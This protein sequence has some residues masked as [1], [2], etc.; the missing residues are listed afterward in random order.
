MT[1]KAFRLQIA[2]PGQS[3]R[4]VVI[5]REVEAGRECDGI[6]LDDPTASRRHVSLDPTD[7]GVVVQDLGSSNGTIVGGELLTEPMVL[8]PGAWIEL[9]E[10]RITIHESREG[11]RHNVAAHPADADVSMDV[12]GER[13]SAALRELGKSSAHTM[14]PG[15]SVRRPPRG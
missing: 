10:T 6:V 15:G 4:V 1:A 13:P 12:E 7:D 2:E 9:G 14:R 3:P 5:E 11:D 8:Q